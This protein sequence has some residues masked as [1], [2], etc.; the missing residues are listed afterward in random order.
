MTPDRLLECL[1]IL[2]WSQRALAARLGYPSHTSVKQW[3]QGRGRVPDDVAR[4]LETLARHH[5]RHP[6]PPRG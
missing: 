6:A 5:E 2:G 1:D 4:W 3:A